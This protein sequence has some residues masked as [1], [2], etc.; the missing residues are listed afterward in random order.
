MVFA[1]ASDNFDADFAG[2]QHLIER[3]PLQRR[4]DVVLS[5]GKVRC[6]QAFLGELAAVRAAADN[7][8]LRFS[9]QSLVSFDRISHGAG[10]FDKTFSHISILF[11]DFDFEVAGDRRAAA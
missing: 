9:P 11:T 6:R 4:V 5:R 7:C 2:G 1:P 3:S 8:Q 10:L